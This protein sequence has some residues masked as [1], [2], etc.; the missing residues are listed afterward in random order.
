MFLAQISRLA[1]STFRG[2]SRPRRAKWAAL[3]ALASFALLL[4]ARAQDWPQWRGLN[5]DGKGGPLTVPAT[6]PT[7]LTTKWK[8]KVGIGDSTPALV[9]GKLYVFARVDADEVLYCLDAATGKNLWQTNYP[10]D[11]VVTGPPSR[12]PGTRSSPV[13]A[14]GKVCTLGVGGILSCFDA[15][16]GALLWR[17]QSTNDY[18][19]VHYRADSSMSPLVLEGRCVAA[20]GDSTNGAVMSFD[21]TTGSYQVEMGGRRNIGFLARCLGGRRQKASDASDRAQ[22]GWLGRRRRQAALANPL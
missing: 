4:G 17:K 11:Y 6:W 8:V 15:S 12:H 2:L 19:G 10:A 3:T 1:F 13:V 7:N 16:T 14:D 18:D 5:R 21:L 22:I 9:G 20:L